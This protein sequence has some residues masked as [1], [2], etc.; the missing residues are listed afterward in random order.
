MPIL[1]SENRAQLAENIA[2]FDFLLSSDQMALLATL[3]R[4][5]DAD[6]DSDA[7]ENRL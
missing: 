3:N 7:L 5:E 6:R 4:G 1:R 2:T